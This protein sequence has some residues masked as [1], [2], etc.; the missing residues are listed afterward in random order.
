MEEKMITLHKWL[1][2]E[3]KL[4]NLKAKNYVSFN[5]EFDTDNGF[6]DDD[7]VESS[8][9]LLQKNIFFLIKTSSA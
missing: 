3:E 2:K 5:G 7:E 1:N 4:L 9:N 8:R 6:D